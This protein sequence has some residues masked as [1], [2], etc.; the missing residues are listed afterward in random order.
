M[1]AE[2]FRTQRRVDVVKGA[3]AGA[4][5]FVLAIIGFYGRRQV[6][7]QAGIGGKTHIQSRIQQKLD[8][9]RESELA[10]QRSSQHNNRANRFVAQGD[11]DA[12]IADLNEA[13]ELQRQLVHDDGRTELA[14][15]LAVSHINRGDVSRLQG[16]FDA[17]L[18]DHNTAF[19]L[20]SQFVHGEERDELLAS[21]YTNRGIARQYQG[22]RGSGFADLDKAVEIY[23]RLIQDK[24]RNELAH[25]LAK[26]HT[27][28]GMFFR[29]Q[30][31]LKDA[32]SAFD[33]AVSI[34]TR[35]LQDD[36]YGGQ[37]AN[38]L[39]VSHNN[40]GTVRRSQGNMRSAVEDFEKA[41]EIRTRLVQQEGRT[42]LTSPLATNLSSLAWLYATHPDESV[43]DGVRAA[44]LAQRACELTD[45]KAFIPLGT[46]AAAHAEAGDFTNAVK[47][48]T[49]AVELASPELR[50]QFQSILELYKARKPYRESTPKR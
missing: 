8:E 36:G 43:R 31:R 48:Q 11:L 26:T 39:A 35:L 15:Y 41:I 7:L 19:E 20:A 22:N 24:G 9:A 23:E 30:G 25:S 3:M 5:V 40:R 42:D 47:W 1:I 50:R 27:T 45:W 6:W 38:E 32:I 33:E 18:R 29:M 2:Y 10:Y 37:I 46:L 17:A 28:R 16:N 12:A 44:K 4:A 34:Q 49:R 13:I 14:Y 21:C